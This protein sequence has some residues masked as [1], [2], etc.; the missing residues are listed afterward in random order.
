MFYL[1][2]NKIIIVLIILDL[3]WAVSAL[4]YDLSA[5]GQIPI[6]FWPF[7]IIC[8]IYP[9]LL[10]IV[11]YQKVRHNH[12]NSY[13]LAF[14]TIP[15]LAYFIGALIYYPTL[16]SAYGFNWLEFGAIFWVAFYGL[17]AVY[18]LFKNPI[19]K[20]PV[21]LVLIFL[22]ISFIIQFLTKSYGYLDFGNLD[23]ATI[24]IIYA[25]ILVNL[26]A[27]IYVLQN[28]FTILN[29]VKKTS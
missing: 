8:P 2:K 27:Y 21:I 11:W 1:M 18:L 10:A 24:I 25:A 22:L 14:A 19:P 9:F 7:I 23:S 13:L 20:M 29:K 12:I 6:Y 28:I 5:I 16:M 15:S 26:S 17:Q 4:V 3:I